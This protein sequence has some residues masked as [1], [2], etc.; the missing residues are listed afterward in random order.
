[1]VCWKICICIAGRV[2]R[3]GAS[4]SVHP[5]N[6][7]T[8]ITPYC[9]CAVCVLTTPQSQGRSM[10]FCRQTVTNLDLPYHCDINTHTVY[11]NHGVT[12]CSVYAQNMSTIEN[13][14]FYLYGISRQRHEIFSLQIDK[15]ANFM[16]MYVLVLYILAKLRCDKIPSVVMNTPLKCDKIFPVIMDTCLRCDKIHPVDMGLSWTH[17]WDMTKYF[18]LTW[19]CH[20]Y[21]PKMW[22]NTSCWNGVVMDTCLRCDKILAVDMG[23]S[24]THAWDMTKYFLLTWRCHGHMPEMEM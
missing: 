8:L 23:L 20:G 13:S 22:Q 5:N 17:A 11:S 21:M 7:K 12:W 2:K 4:I 9:G 3:G 6:V 18:L 14:M 16:L 19:G 15:V 24:W 1:M 10:D